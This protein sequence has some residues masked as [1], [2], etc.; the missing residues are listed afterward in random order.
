MGS[1]A[2]SFVVKWILIYRSWVQT[3]ADTKT[4]SNINPNKIYDFDKAM[5]TCDA[6]L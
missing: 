4:F 2:L 6:G 3:L 1:V 5:L